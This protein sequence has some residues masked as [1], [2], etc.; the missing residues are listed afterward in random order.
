[1][2]DGVHFSVTVA[3]LLKALFLKRKTHGHEHVHI[4]HRLRETWCTTRCCIL[5]GAWCPQQAYYTQRCQ[6]PLLLFI[7]P[8]L[9]MSPP[10]T[11]MG[12]DM[13]SIM[14]IASVFGTITSR[15]TSICLCFGN[16][17]NHYDVLLKGLYSPHL[18][19]VLSGLC[20]YNL[21][22]QTQP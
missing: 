8:W 1:M 16:L 3:M 7:L 4:V 15:S 17:K 10:M 5:S 12:M 19:N 14:P 18:S 2:P 21:E 22:Q 13:G 11:A 20:T 6:W 9:Y